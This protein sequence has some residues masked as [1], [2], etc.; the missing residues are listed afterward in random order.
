[1]S[2]QANVCRYPL[3]LTGKHNTKI[4]CDID[5]STSLLHNIVITVVLH[6]FKPVLVN[7]LSNSSS[8]M[9]RIVVIHFVNVVIQSGAL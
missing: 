3:I 8:K 1:M 2:S 7:V 5:S 6:Y 4:S 9:P